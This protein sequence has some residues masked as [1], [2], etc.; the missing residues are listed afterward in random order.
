M[1]KLVGTSANISMLREPASVFQVEVSQPSLLA[2]PFWDCCK[3]TDSWWHTT[4][5]KNKAVGSFVGRVVVHSAL[6]A[7]TVFKCQSAATMGN[8]HLEVWSHY[9]HNYVHKWFCLL[10]RRR[11]ITDNSCVNVCVLTV[12]WG[13]FTFQFYFQNIIGKTIREPVT[14]WHIFIF[15][16]FYEK[17]KS[18]WIVLKTCFQRLCRQ[19]WGLRDQNTDRMREVYVKTGC[20]PC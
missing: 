17:R 1:C 5:Y 7:T 18:G 14:L 12:K 8:T 19:C 9:F 13:E 10:S 15:C 6:L 4:W 2:L 11:K 16:H 20:K 3:G